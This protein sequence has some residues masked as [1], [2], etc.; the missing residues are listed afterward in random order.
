VKAD[1]IV[2]KIEEPLLPY[3]DYTL[4]AVANHTYKANATVK[5]RKPYL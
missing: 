4:A 1:L 5:N 3:H 2:E